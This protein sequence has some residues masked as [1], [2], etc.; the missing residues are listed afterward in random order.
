MKII[1]IGAGYVGLTCGACFA[2]MG[3]EVTCL[4]INTKR[5]DSLNNGIIPIYEPGLEEMVKSNI[6]E[7]RLSFSSNY[8]SAFQGGPTVCFIAVDTPPM[9]D[10][11]SNMSFVKAVA[12]SIGEH[13]SEYM[14]VVNKSTMPIGSADLVAQ[15]IHSAQEKRRTSYPFDVVSNPE[16]LSE[17]NAIN[18]FMKPDRVIIGTKSARAIAVMKQIYAPFMLNYDRMIIMDPQS[19]EMSKYASNAMLAARISFINELSGLCEMSGADI[20]QVRLG[21]GSDKRIGY[22]YLHPG[23]G[24][25]GSCLPK[26][27]RSLKAQA[28]S[29]GYEMPILEAIEKINIKQK[30]V[31]AKKITSYFADRGG[32]SGKTIAVLGLSFKPDTDDM[33]EAPSLTLIQQL[34]TAGAHLHLYDPVAMNSAK[35]IIGDHPHIQWCANEIDAAEGADALALVTEWKQFRCLPIEKLLSVMKGKVFFDGRNQYALQIEETKEMDYF[36]IGMKPRLGAKS[37]LSET[38]N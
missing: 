36:G 20:N 6:D 30:G 24:F 1:I 8:A 14:V 13:I 31:L 23:P 4:D 37:L 25:G 9:E 21:I 32:V 29:L 10:G 38:L 27:I 11:Q 7:G 35:S 19:A 18:N 15:L 3:H 16:F 22:N 12:L 33:R 2:E 28:N 5:I 26:D 34:L 17:G